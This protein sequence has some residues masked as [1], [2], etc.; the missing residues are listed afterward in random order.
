LTD[1]QDKAQ[2]STKPMTLDE[3]EAYE[4]QWIKEAYPELSDP[5]EEVPASNSPQ[6]KPQPVKYPLADDQGHR[7]GT[8]LRFKVVAKRDDYVAYRTIEDE[9]YEHETQ[10]QPRIIVGYCTISTFKDGTPG[11][12]FLTIGK[13]GHELHGWACRWS[14]LFSMLLQ[15]GVAPNVIYEAVKFQAFEPSGLTNVAGISFCKSI[16][17]LIVRW[18]EKTFAPTAQVDSAEETGYD[19]LLDS[20]VDQ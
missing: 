6:G 12:V 4:V 9:L 18:M 14:H 3:L 11:E 15:Y 16:P 13:E 17:D 20:V 10:L 2:G 19:A 5:E 1:S 8:T 7:M